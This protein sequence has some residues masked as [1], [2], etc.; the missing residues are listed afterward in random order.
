MKSDITNLK[1]VYQIDDDGGIG[2]KCTCVKLIA[3]YKTLLIF[4]TTVLFRL[5]L[6]KEQILLLPAQSYI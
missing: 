4:K 2:E 6:G 1:W 3:L 5:A